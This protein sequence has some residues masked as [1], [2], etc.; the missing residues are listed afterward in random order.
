[1]SFAPVSGALAKAT[2]DVGGSPVVFP[3]I[4]WKLDIDPKLKDV[5]NFRDGRFRKKTLQDATLTLTLVW[6]S[7]AQPNAAANGG[8]VD[9]AAI[10]VKC[11]V[12]ESATKFF[13]VPG[14]IGSIGAANAG[15]E[16]V[17][18]L[19]ITVNLSGGVVTYPVT[20]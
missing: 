4:N 10:S 2:V 7:A 8:I 16:D 14:V 11:Y 5:S 1:M 13:L 18:M 12:D 9:G 17:I 6:D 15:P 19:D 3:S 20:A